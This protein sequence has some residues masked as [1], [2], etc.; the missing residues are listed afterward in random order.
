MSV[1]KDKKIKKVGNKVMKITVNYDLFKKRFKEYD[2]LSNFENTLPELFDMV[3]QYEEDTGEACELD[4][5]GLCCDF[6]EKTLEELKEDY[7]NL[8]LDQVKDVLLENS[9][10]FNTKQTHYLAH[11]ATWEDVY[12]E[13]ED[14]NYSQSEHEKMYSG[15]LDLRRRLSPNGDGNVYEGDYLLLDKILDLLEDLKEVEHA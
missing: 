9:V 8:S 7:S 4:V 14:L 1:T 2:R 5:I 10:T 12:N 6:E 11:I 3:E 13:L 15:V